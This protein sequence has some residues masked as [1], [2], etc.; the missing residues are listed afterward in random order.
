M[1]VLGRHPQLKSLGMRVHKPAIGAARVRAEAKAAAQAAAAVAEAAAAAAAMGISPEAP[2]TVSAKDDGEV[3]DGERSETTE[4]VIAESES[5]STDSTS[6]TS[7]GVG[8]EGASQSRPDLSYDPDFGIILVAA[9][10]DGEALADFLEDFGE[11]ILLLSYS[12]HC[13]ALAGDRTRTSSP[14]ADSCLPRFGWLH[15]YPP[16]FPQAPRPWSNSEPTPSRSS[17]TTT[18]P[19]HSSGCSDS[20]RSS[21]C[22]RYRITRCSCA[23]S[24]CARPRCS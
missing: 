7:P 22:L 13:Q 20:V 15:P 10:V 6:A 12:P 8:D 4:G 19:S 18:R 21:S 11:L 24:D 2:F 3:L 5:T 14:R 1:K 16:L 17:S 23:A 9:D